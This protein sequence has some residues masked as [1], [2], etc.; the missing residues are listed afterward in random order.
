MSSSASGCYD[1]FIL[2]EAMPSRL[3]FAI[4]LSLTPLFE[5]MVMIIGVLLTASDSRECCSQEAMMIEQ[6]ATL[7]RRRS[8]KDVE[9]S[10]SGR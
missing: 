1:D 3:T 2:R 9:A 4:T 7:G 5:S 8:A 6:M 10:Q